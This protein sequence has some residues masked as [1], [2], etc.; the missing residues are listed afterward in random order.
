MSDT[1]IEVFTPDQQEQFNQEELVE[2]LYNHLDQYRDDR[3]SIA[4]AIDYALSS[5]PNK[6]GYVITARNQ[7]SMVGAVVLNLTHMEGYHPEN[8]L[9]YI[10]V[11]GSMRGKGLGKD[12]LQK[13]SN[14]TDGG[15]ALHVEPDNPARQL[16]EKAGFTNKYLE[17]RLDK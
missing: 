6:G 5:E 9:V 13:A 7:G 2:F 12:L 11:D 17:Y 4:S 1:P 14:V 16:Y 3:H 15:I 10:A 8:Y